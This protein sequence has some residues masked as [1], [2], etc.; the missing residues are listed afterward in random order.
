MTFNNIARLSSLLFLSS[1][2][3]LM[4][5]SGGAEVRAQSTHT[6]TINNNCSET[7]WIG[8]NAAQAIQSVTINGQAITTLGGWEMTNGQTATVQVPLTWT[9]GRFWART[10]CNFQSDGTCPA[11]GIG[12][13][14]PPNCCD[15]GGCVDSNGKF[16]LNCAQTGTPPS[17]LAEISFTQNIQESYDVSLVDGGNVSVDMVPD[18]STYDCTEKD[19]PCINMNNLPG[20]N[21][22]N[23]TQD[24]DCFQLFGFGYKF[25]CDPA[26]NLCVNPFFCG[27]PGCSDKS[28][29]AP[30]GI[31]QSLL[32]PSNWD[33]SSIL[34]IA[35]TDC[36]STQQIT[37]TQ[38][39]GST[40]VGCIAPQK[41]CRQACGGSNPL[42]TAPF[43]C[44]PT[45]GF[46][47]KNG[48]VIGSDCDTTVGNTTKGNLWA[49]EGPNA[50]SCFTTGSTDPNCCGCP[51]WTPGFP[52]GAPDGACVAGNNSLWGTNAEPAIT[53]FNTASPTAY[54]F[55][56]D[57]AI[58]LFDC[59]AKTGSVTNYTINFCCVNN[60]G[61]SLC[62]LQ[63][64]DA[65]GDGITNDNE[66]F[67]G[68]TASFSR[69]E[70]EALN[71][72][73]GD[74]VENMFD[75][76]SDNDGLTD[77]VEARAGELDQDRDGRVDD[78][79]DTDGD[80]LP[81][82]ADPDQGGLDLRSPDTD[83]DG[84]ED[85][86]DT[87]SDNEGGSDFEE[88]GGFE[89]DGDGLPD[90]TVDENSDGLLD[91][92]DGQRGGMPLEEMDSDG[93]GV[94]NQLD[95]TGGGG[96]SNCSIAPAGTTTGS[97]PLYLLIPALILVRR[98][99]RKKV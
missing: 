71:D 57:D 5:L 51:S 42:C 23:C 59:Q 25:K 9:S 49:C 99:I 41:L 29:C 46:C 81:D 74:G 32:P 67:S 28:G 38:N 62:N 66:T 90:A 55:P 39:Q 77:I 17:T 24:S 86:V 72:P 97:I 3:A 45:S 20:S 1:L 79:T 94:P 60:D 73:D 98:L 6:I 31:T 54:A 30:A 33:P 75:L 96:N 15:T 35:Q 37:D 63:D 69:R 16:A 44:G 64:S 7:I 58:K 47:E 82:A 21:S 18:P 84:T 36:P 93:D 4:I 70:I 95:A 12:N 27:S 68:V 40:Y 78:M 89:A 43:T 22:P 26:T 88:N 2:I 91:I 14:P 34:A 92:F 61:D 83:G 87:D 19:S 52:N 56:F 48:V 10:G 11:A 76:D 85:F 80:G 8:A 13:N 65:D 50:G 53:S